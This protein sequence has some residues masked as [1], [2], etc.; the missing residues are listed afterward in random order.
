[1]KKFIAP[2]IIFIVI[3]IYVILFFLPVFAQN[4]STGLKLVVAIPGLIFIIAFT[5]V[6]IQRLKE[7]KRGEDDDFSKY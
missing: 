7:I 2:I 3:I 6:F 4:A 5:A 1:M